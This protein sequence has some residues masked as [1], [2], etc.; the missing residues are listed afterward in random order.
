MTETKKE[1][2]QDEKKIKESP[3]GDFGVVLEDMLKAGVHF[4]HRVSSVYPKM[5]PYIYGVRNNIHIINLEE[6]AKKF[7][8]ALQYIE[9]LVS[10]GGNL[11]VVGTKIQIK[12]LSKSFAEEC[13][14][15]YVSERWIGGTFTNFGTIKKRVEYFKE[16]EKEKKEGGLEK[17]KKKERIKIEKEFE[18]LKAK[19]T[20]IKNLEKLPDAIFVLDVKKDV[21][22]VR[23]ALAKGI[24]VVG[25]VDTNV[26]PSLIDYPIPANDDAVSSIKYILEKT[27]EVVLK[28]KPK[29]DVKE[30]VLKTEPKEVSKV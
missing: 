1:K 29:E 24:K 4:G 19:F 25:I 14:L 12:D 21:L 26:D 13:G 20:G 2:I 8:E 22:A 23:E 11:L 15:S 7:N 3:A 10:K 27:K 16:L 5:K 28:S 6:S 17:Y 18:K 9:K 30:V